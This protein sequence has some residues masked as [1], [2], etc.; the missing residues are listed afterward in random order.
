[1]SIYNTHLKHD[2]KV[3][4]VEKGSFLPLVQILYSIQFAYPTYSGSLFS[5]E[6]TIMILHCV[7]HPPLEDTPLYDTPDDLECDIVKGKRKVKKGDGDGLDEIRKVWQ[8]I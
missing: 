5:N 7:I 4:Y 1:M 3:P 2:L 8:M 6:I